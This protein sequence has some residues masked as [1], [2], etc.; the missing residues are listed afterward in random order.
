MRGDSSTRGAP[1]AVAAPRAPSALAGALIVATLAAA[2]MAL[3]LGHRQI[4]TSDEARFALLARDMLTRGIWFGARMKGEVYRNKPPLYPW[5][6]AALSRVAGGVTETTARAPVV[7]AAVSAVFLTALLGHALFGGWAGTWAGAVLATS[8]GFFEHSQLAL[9]DMLVTAFGVAALHAVWRAVT[10][11]AAPGALVC[12]Y[13]CCALGVAAKGPVGLLPLVVAGAWLAIEDGPRA[14]RRLWSPAG[15]ALFAAVTLGW[16]VPFLG[17]GA[18]SFVEGVVWRDWIRWYLGLATPRSLERLAAGLLPWTLVLPLAVYGAARRPRSPEA[19]LA[20]LAMALPLVAVVLSRNQL[21]RYLLPVYPAAALLVGR[22]AAREAGRAAR[23]GA[24]AGWL[25]L[26]GGAALL[27]SPAW[28]DSP[29]AGLIG[30]PSWRAAVVAAGVA[31][32]ATAFFVGLR[33]GRP[34][35]L[36]P[37]V[38]A[39]MALVLGAGIWL[40][41]EQLNRS[42]DYRHLADVLRRHAG[43]AA[44]ASFTTGRAYQL[45][46]YFGRELA[47]GWTTE[48][49]D[50]KPGRFAA[51]M[52]GPGRPVAAVDAATWAEIRD[53]VPGAFVALDRVPIAG[54]DVLVLR[55]GP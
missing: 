52:S 50:Q 40:H 43:T 8:V 18:G 6:I 4:T 32:V 27:A 33:G 26:A 3:P 10:P 21:A 39:G 51:F 13:A 20:L 25:A 2:L 9:P 17:Y 35:I 28:R 46:F 55:R 41:D 23:A 44:A 48:E 24:A 12:F 30:G 22:W 36:V 1:A 31:L 49:F 45:D 14:L 7:L 29:M 38:A 34:A 53:R 42:H 47:V 16:L 15:V 5:A 11:P 37:G 19:T 54:E